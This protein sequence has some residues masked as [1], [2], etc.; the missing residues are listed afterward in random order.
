M[1][2]IA[3]N[4]L[5]ALISKIFAWAVDEEIID[6]IPALRFHAPAKRP[7]ASAS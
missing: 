4:R 1:S 6:S 5:L 7:S 2:G 3:A